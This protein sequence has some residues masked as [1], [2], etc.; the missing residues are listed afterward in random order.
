MQFMSELSSSQT[1]A[2]F[3][4]SCGLVENFYPY[5][6]TPDDYSPAVSRGHFTSI[7]FINSQNCDPRDC[8]S[9]CTTNKV[10]SIKL[11][12]LYFAKGF[13]KLSN[14]AND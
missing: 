14:E 13:A 7:F 12:H 5:T 10:C 8:V 9:I 6:L 4:H 3:Y 2:S 11:V 1:V